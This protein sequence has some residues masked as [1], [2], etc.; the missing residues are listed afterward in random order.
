M[1]LIT[2]GEVTQGEV[3]TI[4]GIKINQDCIPLCE[5]GGIIECFVM[6]YKLA[7]T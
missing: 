4:F 1:K 7:L 5:T 3:T 2:Q 6:C